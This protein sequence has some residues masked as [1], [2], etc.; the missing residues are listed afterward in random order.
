M[1]ATVVVAGC[2]DDLGPSLPSY[3][4]SLEAKLGLADAMRVVAGGDEDLWS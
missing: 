2:E 1:L 3:P 4:S